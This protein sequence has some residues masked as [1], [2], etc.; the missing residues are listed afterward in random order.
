MNLSDSPNVSVILPVY[1]AEKYISYAVSSILS[2]DY[3]DFELIIINDGSTDNTVNILNSFNDSR[4]K[5]INRDNHGL[6]YSLNEGIAVSKGNYICRMDADDIAEKNRISSQIR[7]FLD[8]PSIEFIFTD[9]SLIDDDGNFVC[10][11]WIGKDTSEVISRLDWYNTIYHPS[12]MFKKDLVNRYGSYKKN[13]KYFED[14]DLWLRFKNN[15]VK[16]LYLKKNLLKYRLCKSSVH[17]N[18]KNYWYTVANSCIVNRQ[19]IKAFQYLSR[20]KLNYK[21][22]IFYRCLI[23]NFLI[24]PLIKLKYFTKK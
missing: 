14:K 18:Y 10:N 1:N 12:V 20:I 22:R 17:S 11:A 7:A 19:K 5:I 3:R 8:N 21:I 4:I 13:E 24:L 2:Q 9:V 6:I 15:K 16:F 23:P